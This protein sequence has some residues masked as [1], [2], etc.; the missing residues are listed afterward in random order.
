MFQRYR[1]WLR[2]IRSYQRCR[3]NLVH[4]RRSEFEPRQLEKAE[5]GGR[6]IAYIEERLLR[7]L[8]GWE[9]YRLHCRWQ[10]TEVW[11]YGVSKSYTW[12]GLSPL[13]RE[14]VLFLLKSFVVFT[15]LWEM[16]NLILCIYI[17]TF[18]VHLMPCKICKRKYMMTLKFKVLKIHKFIFFCSTVACN[19]F[20]ISLRNDSLQQWKLVFYIWERRL[21]ATRRRRWRN[22]TSFN[23]TF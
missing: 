6:G 21:V 20:K 15:I 3:E 1:S 14:Q 11:L 12:S 17:R 22:T 4:E 19:L 18:R 8:L 13:W 16:F 5:M 10:V 7:I 23:D 2:T 9:R